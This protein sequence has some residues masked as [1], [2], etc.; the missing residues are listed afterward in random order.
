MTSREVN[1]ILN[2]PN[3]SYPVT[4]AES[5]ELLVANSSSRSYH[6]HEQLCRTYFEVRSSETK[7]RFVIYVFDIGEGGCAIF[8]SDTLVK[9]TRAAIHAV[10]L[11]EAKAS[12]GTLNDPPVSSDLPDNT[13]ES[14]S[15][16]TDPK[17]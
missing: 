14:L 12:I 13:E 4:L 15:S 6:I 1:L 3:P 8:E 10:N 9:A 7:T 5:L 11:H 16:E 2:H 17:P